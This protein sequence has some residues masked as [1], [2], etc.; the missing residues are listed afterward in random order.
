M[1]LALAI[2]L[3]AQTLSVSSEP[4]TRAL[5]SDKVSTV[6]KSIPKPWRNLKQLVS[7]KQLQKKIKRCTSKTNKNGNSEADA[8]ILSACPS[9][10]YCNELGYC[11]TDPLSSRNLQD[12]D[13]YETLCRQG[14]SDLSEY[15]DGS[16]VDCDC[17]DFDKD[18]ETGVIACDITNECDSLP[19]CYD[20]YV[21]FIFNGTSTE[22]LYQAYC[23]EFSKPYTK[24]LCYYYQY[25]VKQCQITFDGNEY[26]ESC[27]S[28]DD[29][30]QGTCT[31]FDCSNLENGN[32]GSDCDDVRA[33][34]IFEKASNSTLTFEVDET[35]RLIQT[36]LVGVS[37]LSIEEQEEWASLTA[38]FIVQ[39]WESNAP[40]M[41]QNLEVNIHILTIVTGGT[42]RR[43]LH[44]GAGFL[45]IAYNTELN[46]LTDEDNPVE[47]IDVATFPFATDENINAYLEFLSANGTGQIA[48]LSAIDFLGV[49]EPFRRGKGGKK[50][51]KGN[52][53]SS[54]NDKKSSKN[55][56]KSGKGTRAYHPP[57]IDYYVEDDDMYFSHDSGSKA[58]K[59]EKNSKN[60]KRR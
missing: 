26:C 35:V 56:K 59:N 7:E 57:P 14:G 45:T 33:S 48:M 36:V 52:K 5:I 11:D 28:V 4:T 46:Y 17:S 22:Y 23:I 31:N 3:L 13:Y 58:S 19:L 32:Q 2:A 21:G 47:A 34:Q 50:G 37:S 39:F 25:D 6:S 1:R 10:Q 55:D 27:E 41:I 42:L 12:R 54:K 44:D 15:F 40:D 51:G 49:R 9:G 20:Y 30:L 60:A 38:E 53:K 18:T 8:G 16:G 43:V 24:S 29:D